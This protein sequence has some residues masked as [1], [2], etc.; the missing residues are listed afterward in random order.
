MSPFRKI[1][2][3]YDGSSHGQRALELAIKI[4][5]C[6]QAAIELVCV[7]D[8][9]PS[10]LGDAETEELI[11]RA[12]FH[13]QEVL[14]PAIQQLRAEG[15]EAITNVL[16][17]PAA[18]AILTVAETQQFDLIVIG[19]RGLSDWQGALIGSTSHRVLHHAKIPVLIVR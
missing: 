12:V 13:A 11:S 6:S 16:E 2:V 17:G 15:L 10:F 1:L 8:K 19:S 3:A 9:V 7:H 4:A 18:E 5:Q 14:E